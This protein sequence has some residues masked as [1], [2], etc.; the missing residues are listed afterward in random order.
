MSASFCEILNSQ[1]NSLAKNK[2]ITDD[3]LLKTIENALSENAVDFNEEEDVSMEII[4]FRKLYGSIAVERF[5][6]RNTC[7]DITR[8]FEKSSFISSDI[9]IRVINELFDHYRSS[10]EY[11]VCLFVLIDIL[12][13]KEGIMA[14]DGEYENYRANVNS[15]IAT[16]ISETFAG[17]IAIWVFFNGGWAAFLNQYNFSLSSSYDQTV[18]CG[19]IL[20]QMR[21]FIVN[22]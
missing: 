6:H 16:P 20:Q 10:W 17:T 15:K 3:L 11:V 19:E 7:A 22:L 9:I 4:V 2:Q 13:W 14:Q 8:H 21:D 12:V 18:K 5:N 1:I